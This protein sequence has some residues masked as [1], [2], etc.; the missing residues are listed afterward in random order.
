MVESWN[1]RRGKEVNHKEDVLSSCK[2]PSWN[3][4]C[5][6][7]CFSRTRGQRHLGVEFSTR[8]F[9]NYMQP[10]TAKYEVVVESEKFSL[11][12]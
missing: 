5:F 7:K 10:R 12:C 6:H 1:I 9:A 3:F 2:L 4:I 8:E 11:G